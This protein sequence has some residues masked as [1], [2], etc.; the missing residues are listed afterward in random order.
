MTHLGRPSSAWRTAVMG[1]G[2]HNELSWVELSWNGAEI[3]D[4]RWIEVSREIWSVPFPFKGGSSFLYRILMPGLCC[5]EIEKDPVVVAMLLISMYLGR[6]DAFPL[7]LLLH[8]SHKGKHNRRRLSKANRILSAKRNKGKYPW[9]YAW[10]DI[11]TESKQKRC[12]RHEISAWV[13]CPEP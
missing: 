11:K 13:L 10:N 8:E 12:I 7:S 3:V 5:I 6:K 2:R 4:F 1:G 9:W